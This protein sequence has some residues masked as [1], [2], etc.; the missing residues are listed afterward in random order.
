MFDVRI[1][2]SFF[3]LLRE[4]SNA[5]ILR[6]MMLVTRLQGDVATGDKHSSTSLAHGGI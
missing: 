6:R 2:M 1:G 4:R 3:S 5:A